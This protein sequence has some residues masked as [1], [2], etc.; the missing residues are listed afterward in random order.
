MFRYAQPISFIFLLFFTASFAMCEVPGSEDN[1]EGDELF[2]ADDLE[3]FSELWAYIYLPE[4]GLYPL[5]DLNDVESSGW[6]A[7]MSY[8]L[9][10]SSFEPVNMVATN[11]TRTNSGLLVLMPVVICIGDFDG[12]GDVNAGDILLFA[13]AYVDGDLSADL[14]GDGVIDIWDQIFFLQL[15]SAGCITF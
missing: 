2:T 4:A 6:A 3:V 1:H 11:P 9:P 7:F 12:D 5:G 8:G 13:Q 15:V 14:T 10:I